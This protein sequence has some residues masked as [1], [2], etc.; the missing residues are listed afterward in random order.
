M[1]QYDGAHNI[2]L[3][4]GTT[5]TLYNTTANTTHP[6]WWRILPG[7]LFPGAQPPIIIRNIE[8]AVLQVVFC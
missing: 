8:N 1:L 6:Y 2:T 5:T 4:C 7:L 3:G